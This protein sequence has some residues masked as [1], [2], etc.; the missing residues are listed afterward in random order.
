M[1]MQIHMCVH[2]HVEIR[3]SHFQLPHTFEVSLCV[4]VCVARVYIYAYLHGYVYRYVDA[5]VCVAHGHTVVEAD[6]RS[7]P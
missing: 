5:H 3:G 6:V 2:I 1:C 7:L 4:C